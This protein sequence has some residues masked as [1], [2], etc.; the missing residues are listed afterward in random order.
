MYPLNIK[1]VD[2]A[3]LQIDW[4]DGKTCFYDIVELRKNCPCANCNEARKKS[5]EQ[6]PS[7][8]VLSEQEVI[9]KNLT[10]LEAHIVGR[11]A[12]SFVWSDGHA[13]GIYAF[14]YL[15]ALCQAG[16]ENDAK[17]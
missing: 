13:E 1:K 9:P 5:R 8:K 14:E 11:Y 10:L 6:G 16:D 17:P 4:D 7:L 3:T 12:I 15:R 2:S